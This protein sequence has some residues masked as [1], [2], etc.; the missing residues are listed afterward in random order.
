MRF[1]EVIMVYFVIGVVMFGGGA[2]DFGQAGVASNIVQMEDGSWSV[3]PQLFAELAGADNSVSQVI[4]VAV[5][6]ISLVFNLIKM[7]FGFLNWP[8]LALQGAGAPPL[9]VLLLG[10]GF[11]AAFY[12]SVGQVIMRST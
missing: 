11:T 3:N 1:S 7:M 5:G 2:L 9:A 4:T 8:I 10:G 12:L 6:G